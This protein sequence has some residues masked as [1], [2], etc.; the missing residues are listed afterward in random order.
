MLY[1]NR[2]S[3]LLW[4]IF[5]GF[6]L[7]ALADEKPCTL[8]HEG[9]YY[10]L[11][12]LKASQD[13]EFKTPGGHSFYLNVCRRMT[14]DP[15]SMGVPDN[16]DVA[17]IVRKDHHDFA[18]GL[19]NT[20]LEMREKGLMLHLSNGSPCPEE[21]NIYGSSSI[22]FLC[23]ASVYGAG[24][25]VVISQFPEDDNQ[26]CQYTVEWQTH[27][28]CPTGE[29]GLISGIIVSLVITMMI[30]L[31]LLIVSS[32]LYNRF[33]LRKRGFDQLARPSKA[34]L[35]EL[36]DFC[37]EL[38]RSTVDNVR[39]SGDRWAR[40]TRDLNPTSHHWSSRDEEQAMMV[41]DP[42]EDD[43]DRELQD[44]NVWRNDAVDRSHGADDLG[45]VRS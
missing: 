17:G 4:V 43:H 18:V 26:A 34:H 10:D 11:N 30:L 12:P 29:R 20:T 2:L 3:A 8:H 16:V 33:V 5:L 19:V 45:S 39:S 23:D 1:A 27:F 15:W 6:G 24:K 40:L 35:L 38:F 36:V 31:M 9:K 22:R 37:M 25:P 44:T 21:D 42:L 28:A 32:T 13:Y 41:A 7:I 14:T